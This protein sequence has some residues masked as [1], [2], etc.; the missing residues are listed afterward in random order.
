MKKVNFTQNLGVRVIHECGLSMRRKG[1][2]QNKNIK[3]LKKTQINKL[4]I[5]IV[6]NQLNN[7]FMISIRFM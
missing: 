1:I 6:S 7:S 4:L 3:Y 5:F 2:K